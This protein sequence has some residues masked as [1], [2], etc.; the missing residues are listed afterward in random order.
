MKK[1]STLMILTLLILP[2][3]LMA[4]GN[5]SDPIKKYLFT[6]NQILTLSLEDKVREQAV[7]EIQTAQSRMTELNS[8]LKQVMGGLEPKLQDSSAKVA[9]SKVLE[10]IQKAVKIEG[11]LKTTHIQLLIRL[12]NLLT[13]EQRQK[14]MK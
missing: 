9:E 8:Q 7:K 13:P 5:D 10:V 11:Q 4:A 2:Q 1:S 14:L 3:S 12:R 6:P